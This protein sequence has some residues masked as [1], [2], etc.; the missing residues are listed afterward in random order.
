MMTRRNFRTDAL[1]RFLALRPYSF[2]NTP[3]PSMTHDQI[4][5]ETARLNALAKS[6]QITIFC[7]AMG[8][9]VR[10]YLTEKSRY[11]GELKNEID[12]LEL[13]AG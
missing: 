4:E 10:E 13:D 12:Y 6:E 11:E 9:D 8:F 3:E 1:A 7:Q 2:S 5:A